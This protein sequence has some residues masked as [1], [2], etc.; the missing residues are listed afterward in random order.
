MRSSATRFELGSEVQA[1]KPSNAT[2]PTAALRLRDRPEN[3]FTVTEG[4]WQDVPMPLNNEARTLL[5]LMAAVGA[6]PFESQTPVEAREARAALVPP[7]TH[8]CDHT[9]DV[10]AGGVPARLYRPHPNDQQTGLL[11]WFHGGGW[12]IGDL[13]SHDNVCHS[14]ASRSGQSVLSVAYRLAPENPFPAGLSDC[15]QATRWA[16]AH[17]AELGIDP[18]RVAVGGDSAGANLAAVVCQ[19]APAPIAFQLLVY[20]ITDA[21]AGSAS[22]AENADGYFLT[23]AGMEWF[24][25]HYLSGGQ[26]S[27]EDPRVSPLLAADETLASCPPTMLI[28]AGFDPLRDEGIEYAARLAD[29]GTPTDHIHVPGQIHGFFSLGHMLREGRV[30]HAAAAQA[31]ADA[32]STSA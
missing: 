18:E 7:V 27:R 4:Y 29:A 1:V 13:E 26:G 30:A 5:D 12:V 22:Y 15:V 9:V 11:I 6:P 2:T 17:A 8:P 24:I 14:L 10:D 32:L 23:A 20:P 31:V 19:I 3:V 25:G 28:T 16:V 21:R